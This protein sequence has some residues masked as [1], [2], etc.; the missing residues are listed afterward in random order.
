[1]TTFEIYVV[2]ITSLNLVVAVLGNQWLRSEIWRH[3]HNF[4]YHWIWP[5]SKFRELFK[6][7]EKRT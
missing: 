1:M 3:C 2:V 5:A 6:G 4:R 7:S